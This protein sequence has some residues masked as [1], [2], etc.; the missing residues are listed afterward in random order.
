MDKK[1]GRQEEF[2]PHSGSLLELPLQDSSGNVT[3]TIRI[4]LLND[5]I[6]SFLSHN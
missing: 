3:K 4:Y 1:S 6:K 5:T 2:G